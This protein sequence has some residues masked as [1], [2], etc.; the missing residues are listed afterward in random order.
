MIGS[1]EESRDELDLP[2][3]SRGEYIGGQHWRIA[4][5]KRSINHAMLAANHL[6]AMPS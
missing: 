3:P 5:A 6:D 2:A 1:I 4:E